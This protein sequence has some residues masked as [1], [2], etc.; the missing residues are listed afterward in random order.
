M[1][2]YLGLW[3]VILFSFCFLSL[4]PLLVSGVTGVCVMQNPQLHRVHSPP[5]KATRILKRRR[6][7]S[8]RF[9]HQQMI[10]PFPEKNPIDLNPTQTFPFIGMEKSHAKPLLDL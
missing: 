5:T 6:F 8:P 10:L 9:W 4:V 7:P 1:S 2:K 3:F